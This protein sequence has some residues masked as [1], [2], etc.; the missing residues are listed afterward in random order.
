[1]PNLVYAATK[2]EDFLPV[3]VASQNCE[4]EVLK[5]LIDVM[6]WDS[7]GMT[8]DYAVDNFYDF[9]IFVWMHIYSVNIMHN[10]SSLCLCLCLCLNEV[11]I[12]AFS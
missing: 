9:L 5:Y 11:E 8:K 4:R 1:M 7:L 6:R 2:L 12:D 3:H 10:Q